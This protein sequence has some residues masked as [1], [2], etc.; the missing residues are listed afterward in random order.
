MI[1]TALLD[2]LH[3]LTSAWGRFM[4]VLCS[5]AK[6]VANIYAGPSTDSE[7]VSQAVM[8]HSAVILESCDPWAKIETADGYAGW[9]KSCWIC[10]EEF[11][12][13]LPLF[14]TSLFADALIYPHA[15]SP[16]L[17]RMVITT[18]I[19]EIERKD[20][21]ICA[22]TPDGRELWVSEES[23][24]SKRPAPGHTSGEDIVRE[25]Q[26]FMGTPYLWGGSTPF[27]IDCSGLTQLVFRLHGIE[28]G[29]DAW[30]QAEDSKFHPVAKEDIAAGDLVFFTRENS[31]RRISHVGIATGGGRFIHAAGSGEGVCVSSLSDEPYNSIY[32]EASRLVQPGT[33]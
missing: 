8:G 20:G 11:N 19:A 31:T 9:V 1:G 21:F 13:N 16:A 6:N 2:I 32:R 17:T 12:P 14:V 5:I 23:I 30:M 18:R 4:P 15:D 25:A 7:M 22:R 3:I 26:R 33:A 24:C 29:R 27:G 28:L 10:A